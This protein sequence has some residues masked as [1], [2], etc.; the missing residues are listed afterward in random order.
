MTNRLETVWWWRPNEGPFLGCEAASIV[1]LRSIRHIVHASSPKLDERTGES[2]IDVRR[3]G[4][5]HYGCI[6][7]RLYEGTGCSTY[8][9]LVKCQASLSTCPSRVGEYFPGSAKI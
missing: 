9:G 7:A 3:L 2:Y 8:P 1:A 4:L 6:I 5:I